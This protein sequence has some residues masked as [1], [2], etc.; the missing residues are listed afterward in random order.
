MYLPLFFWTQKK[1]TVN[2]WKATD[3][4]FHLLVIKNGDKFMGH[5]LIESLQ[6]GRNLWS[7]GSGQ[8]MLCHSVHIL[9]LV[10]LCNP[11]IT[12]TWYELI[13]CHL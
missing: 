10:L 13:V 2:F 4:K 11:N 3:E 12:S 9:M 7:D 8:T 1:L 6:K 5:K